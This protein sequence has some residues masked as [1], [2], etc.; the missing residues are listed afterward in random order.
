MYIPSKN[1]A[2]RIYKEHLRCIEDIVD[3]KTAIDENSVNRTIEFLA[4]RISML[5]GT[6]IRDSITMNPQET[7]MVYIEDGKF[8]QDYKR[9]LMQRL[10]FNESD[11]TS[12]LDSMAQEMSVWIKENPNNNSDNDYWRYEMAEDKIFLNYTGAIELHRQDVAK[13]A[14]QPPRERARVISSGRIV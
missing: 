11:D 3:E 4:L 9:L 7:R 10:S 8:S 2:E 6:F 1:I 14:A 13:R 5:N 12:T